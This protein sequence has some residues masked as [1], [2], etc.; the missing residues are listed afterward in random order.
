MV[1][2]I[3][4][5]ERFA[6]EKHE[7]QFRKGIAKEPYVVHLEEVAAYVS[8][9][10]GTQDAIAG[11]WLHD[12]IEDC[13]PTNFEE[14]ASHFGKK[15]ASIVVELTDDKSLPKQKRKDLQ[16]ANASK[17]SPEASIIK[18]ADKTSNVGSLAI[19]PPDNW[20]LDRRLGYI[21][22]AQSVVGKLPNLPRKGLQEFENKCDQ[23][24]LQAYIDLGSE[25][26]AQNA[27]L[28]ILERRAKRLG[29]TQKQSDLFLKRLMET[30]FKK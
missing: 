14:I 8:S 22:W 19:S 4:R 26:Q 3:D 1:D 7:G 21:T 29:A 6:R 27:S 2:L 11:A 18:L 16:I 17:K 15:I 23:A 12:T 30:S 24:E 10:G 28:T 9:W 13:P 5:A 20:A 25:R